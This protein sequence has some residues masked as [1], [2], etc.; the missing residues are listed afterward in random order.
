[1]ALIRG[2]FGLAAAST[3]IFFYLSMVVLSFGLR[4]LRRGGVI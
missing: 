3:I 4:T 2:D 1:M